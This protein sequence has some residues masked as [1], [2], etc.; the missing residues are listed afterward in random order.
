MMFPFKKI[1]EPLEKTSVVDGKATHTDKNFCSVLHAKGKTIC[2]N[3]RTQELS[4]C[5]MVALLTQEQRLVR[6]KQLPCY[7]GRPTKTTCDT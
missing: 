5:A 4:S 7:D 3:N 6:G 1:K 2:S